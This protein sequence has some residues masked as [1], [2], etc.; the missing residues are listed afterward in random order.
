[1]HSLVLVRS[2]GDHYRPSCHQL[3][4]RPLPVWPSGLVM[5]VRYCDY[6]TMDTE[7]EKGLKHLLTSATHYSTVCPQLA[8][9]LTWVCIISSSSSTRTSCVH[10]CKSVLVGVVFK[11]ETRLII[12]ILHCF[13]DRWTV[14]LTKGSQ[15]SDIV[16]IPPFTSLSLSLSRHMYSRLRTTGSWWSKATSM[17]PT[18]LHPLYTKL[19]PLAHHV[20]TV[21]S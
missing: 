13:R 19:L 21:T 6:N 7:S 18:L 2:S 8:A 14:L 17:V 12:T 10:A 20:E 9:Y 15:H 1:M 16:D 3:Q 4:W 11:G 5:V